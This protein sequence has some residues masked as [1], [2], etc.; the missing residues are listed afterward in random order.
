MKPRVSL[1]SCAPQDLADGDSGVVVGDAAGDPAKGRESPYVA[2]P[3]GFGA[4][5]IEGHDEHDAGVRQTQ[6]EELDLAQCAAEAGQRLAEIDLGLAGAMGQRHE[7]LAAE[8][9]VL[10][11]GLLDGGVAALVTLLAQALEESLGAVALLGGQ[12]LVGL[13]DRL[14]APEPRAD[15]GFGPVCLLAVA[16]RLALGQDLLQRGPV[17]P[18]LTQDLALADGPGPVRGG[19]FPSIVPCLDTPPFPPDKLPPK[20]ALSGVLDW[21]AAIFDR[22]PPA[23]IFNRPSH[24]FYLAFTIR[25]EVIHIPL[26]IRKE[27]TVIL[28][29]RFRKGDVGFLFFT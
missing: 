25:K 14:D 23:A 28:F 18:G 5:A 7:D 13:E 10:A 16:R 17:H 20:G 4:L 21:G 19:G 2:F 29:Y 15:L 24:P 3:E 22:P 6:D 9:L 8:L 27:V 26:T 12:F 1:R 11:H